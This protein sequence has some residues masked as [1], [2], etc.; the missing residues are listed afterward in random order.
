M[1]TYQSNT[2]T[3]DTL[4]SL[5]TGKI[6]QHFD[7]SQDVDE[8]EFTCA[9]SSPS[10]HTAVIGSFDRLRVFNWLPK[11]EMWE[12]ASVKSIPN[13]Y[14]ITAMSWRKDGSRITVV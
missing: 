6:L 4:S 9:I 11:R 14:T 7:Y 5:A 1:R 10:G 3:G 8:K 12:E 13:L 2:A